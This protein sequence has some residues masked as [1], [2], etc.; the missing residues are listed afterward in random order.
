[1]NPNLLNS[2]SF[3]RLS[4]KNVFCENLLLHPVHLLYNKKFKVNI[5]IYLISKWLEIAISVTPLHKLFVVLEVKFSFHYIDERGEG[6]VLR[7]LNS[8]FF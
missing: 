6:F 4:R 5:K 2:P 8:I 1:M 7:H 3:V